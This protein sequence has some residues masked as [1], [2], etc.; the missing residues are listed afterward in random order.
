MTPGLAGRSRIDGMT[1]DDTLASSEP[2]P[3]A[4][5]AS[6]ESGYVVPLVHVRV[7]EPVVK[8]GLW[9]TVGVVAVAGVVEAP[10]VGAAAG[11][12]Y[13]LNRRHNQQKQS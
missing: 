1:V 8:V 10:V 6:S 9:G 11:A 12:L 7:P 2:A 5:I 3:S 4:E 13:L